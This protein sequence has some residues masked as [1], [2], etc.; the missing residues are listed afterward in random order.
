[1]TFLF[2]TAAWPER[3][4]NHAYVDVVSCCHAY[5]TNQLQ[6]ASFTFFVDVPS[7]SSYY[8]HKRVLG[9][10]FMKMTLQNISQLTVSYVYTKLYTFLLV[11]L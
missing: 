10:P 8:L 1:M 4:Y 2:V 11:H 7:V 5:D 9:G 3:S 6:P